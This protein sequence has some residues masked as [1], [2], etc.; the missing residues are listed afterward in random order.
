MEYL[1]SGRSVGVW[2]CR[3]AAGAHGSASNDVSWRRCDQSRAG[4]GVGGAGTSMASGGDQ[5]L[6]EIHGLASDRWIGVYGA[7]GPPPP[8]CFA[9]PSSHCSSPCV[10]PNAPPERS[11]G[12][13]GTLLTPRGRF[14][15][16]PNATHRGPRHP[17]DVL[18]NVTACTVESPPLG[19]TSPSGDGGEVGPWKREL[20]VP[21]RTPSHPPRGERWEPGEAARPERG[22]QR[23]MLATP[24][25]SDSSHG[26]V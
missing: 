20:P 24:H 11:T 6:E 15:T 18:P 22:V 16:V 25:R 13:A 4:D 23:C 8:R 9:A 26:N 3:N 7:E 12:Y 14:F 17:P 2:R 1:A 10:G 21:S 19:A 5:G